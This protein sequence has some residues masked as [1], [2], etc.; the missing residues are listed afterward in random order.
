MFEFDDSGSSPR[1]D[2]LEKA[3]ISTLPL[4]LWAVEMV[5]LVDLPPRGLRDAK[6][7]RV[8]EDCPA[9]W[10]HL[11]KIT[12]S[13]HKARFAFFSLCTTSTSL[14]P[15]FT[16]SANIAVYRQHDLSLIPSLR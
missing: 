1:R 7:A 14:L 4:L 9:Q 11:G 6:G 12:Q 16:V 13:S 8:G 2:A 10:Q 3:K 15:R 5:I